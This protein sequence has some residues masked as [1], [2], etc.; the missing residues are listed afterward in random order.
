MDFSVVTRITD[1]PYFQL[2]HFP[3][4]D[5]LCTKE[6]GQWVKISTRDFIAKSELLARALIHA[7]IQ[8]GDRIGTIT[9][10]NQAHWNICDMAIALAGAV[11]V[12]VYPNITSADYQHIFKEAEIKLCF[13]SD[14]TLAE[15]IK[16]VQSEIP[17]LKET[18]S[19]YSVPGLRLYTDLIK[20]GIASEQ[21]LVSRKDSIK[22][23][24]LATIIYTS[25]TTGTP[26]GVMLSHENIIS[27]AVSCTDRIPY[28]PS[29]VALSFLPVNHIYERMLHY[30]YMITGISIYF[31]ES[32][33]TIGDNLREVKPHIFTA[34]PRL[35]EKVYDKIMAKG[36]ELKGIKK[37]LFFWSLRLA[38]Q[39][40]VKGK[41]PWYAFKLFIA[42]KL[43]FKKWQAAL[44]GRSQAVAS[45]SAPLQPRLA[46][47]YLAAGIPVWE[48]YGLTETSPVVS[49]N[50]SK[51]DG[52]R[53]GTVGRIIR[54]VQVRLAEDGEILVKGP[55]V[56]MGYYKKPDLTA[57][58]LTS[59]GWF[60]TG[61]IGT[62]V[63][64]EFLKITDRKK[65][66]FKTS[67]GKY[68]APQ[69]LENAF[70]ESEFIE[71]ILVTGES[72]HFPAA[73]VVPSFRNVMDWCKTNNIV[74]SANEDVC[75]NKRVQM[76]I[77]SEIDRI[78]E[79]FGS[80]EQIKKIHLL[81]NEWTIDTGELTPNLKLKRKF[82]QAKFQKEIESMYQ[83]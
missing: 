31:A 68:I 15:K 3:K 27:N 37:I 67:G 50:C 43:V 17:S 55:N 60:H 61:D 28:H 76:L 14:V 16:S 58:V 41:S 7:G 11:N 24:E 23:S 71:Q 39:Y 82:I 13:V 62:M 25:G 42:R 79:R 18:L 1:V 45:G 77:M 35:L 78:N 26:K 38:E 80:W 49:V 63:E 83:S 66:I 51:E 72:K 46:R 19:F 9:H 65:E 34:V 20:D 10:V 74:C 54:G 29:Y 22:P 75:E 81:P 48:G 40:D 57:E 30:L 52:I 53:I 2:A 56:M 33:D 73:L 69:P 64:G 6:N 36:S 4:D 8:K 59:D 70:K 12:P 5:M 32:M 21:E 44:G 47:V